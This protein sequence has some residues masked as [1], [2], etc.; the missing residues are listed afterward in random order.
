M[1]S[2]LLLAA[3]LFLLF[4]QG[5]GGSLAQPFDQMK[6]APITVYRLQNFEPPAAQAAAAAAAPFQVPPQ[7]QQWIQQGAAMLPPGLIPPGLIPGAT[8]PAATATNDLKFHGFRVLGWKQ[9]GDQKTHDDVLDLFGHESNFV[10]Q[11]D[12]CMYAEF[13]FSIAQPGP[14]PADIL[15]SLSCD[16]AVAASG[17]QWPYANTGLPADSAKKVVTIV[18][19]TFGG[20]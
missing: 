13:G 5:C 17:F 1:R 16:Q 18:Q 6:S 10:T 4:S 12:G 14:A 7:I 9:I 2:T 8:A 11:H 3:P 19:S 15:V 20:T